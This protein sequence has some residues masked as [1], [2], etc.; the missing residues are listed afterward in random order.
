L[1][2]ELVRYNISNVF[3]GTFL[4]VVEGQIMGKLTSGLLIGLMFTVAEKMQ[5]I[6][7]FSILGDMVKQV[8]GDKAAVL[9]LV[10]PNGDANVFDPLPA[11]AQKLTS[12]KLVFVNG[13]GLDSWIDRLT[14]AS[15]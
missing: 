3:V 2:A 14:S 8:A 4:V 5:V 9:T 7:S 13:L 12:A 15:G 10:G 11:D 1:Q 6:A